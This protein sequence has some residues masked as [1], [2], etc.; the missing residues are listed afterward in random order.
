[1]SS[2]I[3][4]TLMKPALSGLAGGA[5]YVL[6][7]GNLEVLVMDKILPGWLVIG[8]VVAGA[9]Y[10]GEIGKNYILPSLGAG[11]KFEEIAISA[12]EPALTGAATAGAVYLLGV[13]DA[14]S[15]L[16]AFLL[17]A[18]ANVAGDYAYT[19]FIYKML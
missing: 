2:T 5:L 18:G 6:I 3:L 9:S 7:N 19:N 4:Q 15:L 8:F 16:P 10:V 12:L 17:G 13:S 11:G 1:M 14:G